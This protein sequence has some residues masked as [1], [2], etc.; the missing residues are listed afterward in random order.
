MVVDPAM[1]A[2]WPAVRMQGSGA[3]ANLLPAGTGGPAPF[4]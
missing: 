3:S 1:P 2:N 4:S